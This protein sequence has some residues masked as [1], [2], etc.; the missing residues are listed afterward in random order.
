MAHNTPDANVY[1]VPSQSRWPFVGSISML[2]LMV[3][4]ASWLND[5]SWGRWT[6]FVGLAML[7]FTL[8]LWFGDVIRESVGGN[9]NRQVDGSFR[10]GMVWFIFSEVMFFAAFFGALFYTRVYG[11]P[12]L[13]GEGHGVATNEMLW[14]GYSA[15]WPSNGPGGIGG[16]FQTIPA[17]GL[18]LLNTLILLSSGAT[19]TIAHHALKAGNRRQ[20][21]IWLGATV[22]LGCVF[23]FFQVEEY[24]HA[25]GELNLTLG[26]GI[27]GSTFFMLTGF[28]G[29]H[30]ALGTIML[31]VMWLRSAKGH[32]TRDN[33]F[34]FEA[35]AWYWHFVDVVWLMLFLFV[36]VL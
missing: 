28:H 29:A 10:M 19:L 31:I 34:G 3:G 24:M 17:W 35:A 18:P 30:V 25:Y 26:S 8:F 4:V 11:L 27:Y 32:F 5:A 15:A 2:V 12:W 14:D 21:L 1:F 36:Y 7:V 13:G 22:L 23:L 20:L 33:H 6:F 16:M 9:Y